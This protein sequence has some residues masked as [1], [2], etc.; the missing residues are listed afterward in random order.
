MNTPQE[1]FYDVS[2]DILLMFKRDETGAIVRYKECS[3]FD[4]VSDEEPEEPAPVPDAQ[5]RPV[6]VKIE[7]EEDQVLDTIEKPEES[8]QSVR[9]IEVMDVDAWAKEQEEERI[10]QE[11]LEEVQNETVIPE[12]P[13][14]PIRY[15]RT[16]VIIPSQP[17]P[18]HNWD[19]LDNS[20]SFFDRPKKHTL[21]GK[22]LAKKY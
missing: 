18:R 10:F 15:P 17:R 20:R 5:V 14:K 16:P 9:E 7:E 1:I 8:S 22:K 11:I 6:E 13:Q 2:G 21:T 4:L 19:E 3:I 12:T